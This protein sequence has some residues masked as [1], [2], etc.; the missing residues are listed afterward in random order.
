MSSARA[1]AAGPFFSGALSFAGEPSGTMA[2]GTLSGTFTA[3]FDS[4]PAFTPAA[5]AEAMLMQQ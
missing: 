4:I 3:K 2:S 1:A 5:G